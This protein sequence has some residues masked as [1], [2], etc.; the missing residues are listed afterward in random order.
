M[1]DAEIGIKELDELLVGSKGLVYLMFVGREIK[2]NEVFKVLNFH[3]V[4]Q[5]EATI[6]SYV[7]DLED[8]GLIE[9]VKKDSGPGNPKLRRASLDGIMKTVRDTKVNL[10]L[11][12]SDEEDLKTV[13]ENAG[14]VINGFPEFLKKEIDGKFSQLTWKRSLS[15]FISYSSLVLLHLNELQTSIDGYPPS[16]IMLEKNY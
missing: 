1:N 16:L 15:S 10:G 12:G 11:E 6:Y 13:L 8:K 7:S 14:V 4:I 5:K 9:T 3:Q 2:A